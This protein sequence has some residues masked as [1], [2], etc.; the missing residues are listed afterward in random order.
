MKHEDII[1]YQS[2]SIAELQAEVK[3]LETQLIE[4]SMKRELGQQKNVRQ[5]KTIRQDIARLKTIIRINELREQP[6]TAV[7][8][9]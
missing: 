9:K 5:G 4:V 2:Q 3:K 6:K 8:S 7:E 1:K